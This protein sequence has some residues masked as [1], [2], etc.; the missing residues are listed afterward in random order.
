MIEYDSIVIAKQQSNYCGQVLKVCYVCKQ[1]KPLDAFYKRASSKDGYDSTCKCCRNKRSKEIKSNRIVLTE[2][3]KQ[4]NDCQEIKPLSEFYIRKNCIDGYG[5]QCKACLALKSKQ[6]KQ[7]LTLEQ[8]EQRKQYLIKYTVDNKDR[9]RQYQK[10]YRQLNANK[11]KEADRLRYKENKLNKSMSVWLHHALKESKAER[12]WE[13]LV[14]YNLCQLR[15]HLE[16]QFTSEMNWDN[17]GTYWEIDHIIPQNLFKIKTEQ[18]RDFQI[19]WSLANLRPLEKSLNR[20]RPKDGS[21]ISNE[22][23]QQI[24]SYII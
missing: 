8:K 17:Y 1:L 3:F 23:K 18:D 2:G 7:N 22:I 14:P 12:H 24:L 9:I 6:Y 5:G 13:D 10:Q 4:C 16:S 19:C 20:Q 11:I 15:Q 21:D